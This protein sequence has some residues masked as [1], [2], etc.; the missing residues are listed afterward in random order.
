MKPT[1][2]FLFTILL[3]LATIQLYAQRNNV[4]APSPQAASLGKFGEIPVNIST[5]AMNY[6][7]PLLTLTE[8]S[9]SVP[10]SLAYNYNGF[11]P[12]EEPGWAG[13]GWSLNAGGVITR[14]VQGIKDEYANR[15]YFYKGALIKDFVD[16]PNLTKMNNL[17]I[18]S[19]YNDSQPDIFHFAFG[20]Y[21]GKFVFDENGTPR[22]ISDQKIKI[23]RGALVNN[24]VHTSSDQ[25]I[26]SFT[27]TTED[28]TKYFFNNYEFSRNDF[29]SDMRWTTSAWH[30][31]EIVN[32]EGDRIKFYYTAINSAKPRIQLSI[33]D[34]KSWGL[35]TS[36]TIS[37]S[38][39]SSGSNIAYNYSE[40]I[41]LT[42]IEGTNWEAEFNSSERIKVVNTLN[43]YS[44]KLDN[45]QLFDKT[46]SPRKFLKK[47]LF[48]YNT[49]TSL[50]LA[51]MS[52]QEYF[53]ESDKANPYLFV[54]NSLP[55]DNINGDSRSID[56]WG[57]YN[58]QPNTSLI[59]VNTGNADM[60]PRFNFTLM[61]AMS[62]ITYPTQGYTV[63]QYEQNDYSY[64]QATVA[65]VKKIVEDT[66]TFWWDVTSSGTNKSTNVPV[67]VSVPTKCKIKLKAQGSSNTVCYNY[68]GQN[69]DTYQEITLQPGTYNDTYFLNLNIFYPC[70]QTLSQ[71]GTNITISLSIFNETTSNQGT[72]GGLRVK[73]M[74]DYPNNT[75]ISQPVFREFFYKDFGNPS[76]SSGMLG[77]QAYYN[78]SMSAGTT[79]FNLFRSQAFNS[80]SSLP[81]Y[82]YNVEEKV[83]TQSKLYTFT[84]Y[85]DNTDNSGQNAFLFHKSSADAIFENSSNKELGAYESYDFARSLPK[86]TTYKNNSTGV[87]AYNSSQSFYIGLPQYK[88][89][90]IHNEYLFPYDVTNGA[91]GIKTY[92]VYYVKTY[93][94]ITGWPRKVLEETVDNGSTGTSPVTVSTSYSYDN[95]AHL[96]LTRQRV[97]QSDGTV[98][99]TSFKY[100]LDYT[101]VSGK[102]SFITQM[103]NDNVVNGPLE[104]LVVHESGST[105][106]VINFEINTYKTYSSSNPS[107][108]ILILPYKNFTFNSVNPVS[109]SSFTRYDGLSD[110]PSNSFYRELSVSTY[111]VNNG[112]KANLV[113]QS[114]NGGKYKSVYLWGYNWQY[115]L[116]KIENTDYASVAAGLTAIS[117]SPSSLNATT[118]ET[119]LR[120]RMNS[121]RDNLAGTLISSYTY[122]P[123]IGTS[124]VTAPNKLSTFYSYDNLGRLSF[125][126]DNNQN[127]L[128]K[129]LYHYSGQSGEI[130]STIDWDPTAIS[131]VVNNNGTITMTVGVTGLV[132]PAYAEFTVDAGVTWQRANIGDAYF[133][134]SFPYSPAGIVG[135][136]ARA[137]DLRGRTITGFLQKCQ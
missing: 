113:E 5:G 2:K 102:A 43:S 92:S 74:I 14:T 68:N 48:N 98:L 15:G 65:Q 46:T 120:A 62:Q 118:D 97:T 45:I 80:M 39:G 66:R 50:R 29:M 10:V 112:L 21:S 91:S 57:Y 82:Y 131:C 107:R 106:N 85:K 84:S 13:L 126:K 128:K 88:I 63:I 87:T 99:E 47:F 26:S 18:E 56:Y 60:E 119:T 22:I 105:R 69:L 127:I 49:D 89:P 100:P 12:S 9:L 115:P 31:S 36:G 108:A 134:V 90:S 3:G 55:S 109:E 32:L 116:A 95:P 101:T 44:R 135:F 124:S 130:Y 75:I 38:N 83:G 28:G 81:L 77:P 110:S 114:V 78:L 73:N 59:P 54:Y 104:K 37:G 71:V 70:N 1:L 129:Y 133:L 72:C 30:L 94:T 34:T 53:S 16:A 93:Y 27:I 96:Q 122:K 4:I 117:S 24:L 121:L 111:L 17:N 79:S 132:S 136:D 6:S 11:R 25:S 123:I 41:F 8:G 35:Y 7:I 40:E 67:T 58:G 137:S 23:E 61:G 103:V 42:K 52:V 76:L 51:L 125:I 20:G 86:T 33:S 64:N 19:A